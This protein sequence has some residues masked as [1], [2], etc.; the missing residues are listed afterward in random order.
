MRHHRRV[1]DDRG[2][3]D[4]RRVRDIGE[5]APRAGAIALAAQQLQTDTELLVLGPT[6]HHVEPLLETLGRAQQ[7]KKAV[8]QPLDGR[9]VAQKLHIDQHVEQPRPARQ[10]IGEPRCRA[11]DLGNKIEQPRI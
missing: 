2:E 5:A 7:R 3:R 11:D 4:D 1:L 9:R 6:P 8:A 10:M